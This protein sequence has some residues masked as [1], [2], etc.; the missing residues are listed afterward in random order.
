M[1]CVAVKWIERLALCASIPL[2]LLM[3]QFAST[4]GLVNELLFPPPTAVAAALWDEFANGTLM[5]DLGMSTMRVAVG[6]L[7]GAAVAIL[8]GLLTGRYAIVSNFLTP[9]FQLLRPIPP[10]AFVP[11]VILWF[12]LTE[13][14]SGFWYSGACSSPFGSQPI[15]ACIAPT[16]R[17]S[18]PPARLAPPTGC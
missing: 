3:W 8:I 18:A 1:N 11:I 15:W 10:I 4:S 14:E 7:T 16:Q 17:W 9:I 2:F 12:G 5:L 13:W 6:F